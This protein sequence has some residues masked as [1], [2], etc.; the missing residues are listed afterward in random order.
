VVAALFLA[1]LWALPAAAAETPAGRPSANAASG[2][3]AGQAGNQPANQA[4]K[5]L[6]QP[7]NLPPRVAQAQRFLARRGWT[8]GAAGRRGWR[9][10]SA[11]HRSASAQL[12]A[13]PQGSG[14]QGSAG[15][16]TWKPLG[17]D[18]VLTPGY[19]LVTGRVSAMALD[20]S[21]TTGNHLYLG[22]AGD[23]VWAASNAATSSAS[24][25]LFTPLTDGID[26]LSGAED[27]SIS[28]G[29][30]TV[31]PGGSC[32]TGGD[33]GVILA[34]TGDPNDALDSYY[35]AGI[36]RSTDCG[37]SWSLISET[38]DTEWKFLGEG[39]A[40]FAW[41]TVNPQV[42]VAAVSQAYEGTLVN[43]DLTN[44]SYEGLYYS[45]DGGATWNLAT[46]TDGSGQD[47]QGP[48]DAF[49][50]PD[51]NAATAVVWNP[52][53]QLF[54]AAVR[55]HGYYQSAD[56]VT[57]TRMTAQPGAGLTASAC[58]TN[59]GGQIGSIGCPIFRGSLAVNPLTGDTF[60]WTVDMYN[61]DQG[62]WQDQCSINLGATACTN[63]TVTFARQ[64]DTAALE[65]NTGNGPATIQN[66]DYNL[67]LAAVPY[68]LQQGA[69]TWLLAGA[70]DLW[71]CSLAQGCVWRNTTNSTTCMSAQV[72]EFQHALAWDAANPLEIFVGNDG[73]LW[74]SL[75]AIGETS[76]VCAASD[77]THFQNLNGGLGS[78]AEVESLATSGS[79]AYVMMAGLGD[80][81]TAGLKSAT[82]VTADWPRILG[83]NGGPVVVDAA[84]SENWYV[85]NQN[86][87][88]IYLCSDPTS[89][90]AAG[91]G[92]TAVVNDAD[93]GGDGDT[94]QS[95]APFLIDPLDPSQ[96]LVG[97]CRV[98][99][100]PASGVG[101]SATNAVSPILDS[102]ATNVSCSGDAL[103]R[104]VA[105]MALSGGKEVV[106]VG[107]YGSNNG[108]ANLPGHVLSATIDPSSNSMPVWQDLTLNP[109][110]NSSN[111]L[112]K[113]GLDISSILVD[114]HDPTGKTVY[115]TVEGFSTTA[116]QVD[117]VYQSADGGA[118][119]AAL[120][121]NLPFTPVSGLAVDP[122]SASTVYLA[123]DV[124]VFFTTQV[125]GCANA[126]STC[127]SAFGSGLPQAPVVEL[128]A[129]P[130]TAPAQ[131]LTA[132]TFGRGVWQTALCSASGS[133][134]TSAS[135]NA[136]NLTFGNQ[137]VD[138]DSN[139]PLAVK[140]TNTGNLALTIS[141]IVMSDSE[142]FSESDDC[143]SGSVAA[144]ASCTVNVTFKP[145]A[146][147]A[148]AGEMAIDANVCGGQLTVGL[149]GT[150]TSTSVVTF[151][152]GALA[153]GNVAENTPV[154]LS[155]G[156]NT[157][158]TITAV[159]ITQ[160][161]PFTIA[162]NTCVA[163]MKLPGTCQVTVRFVPTASG[164]VNGILSFSDSAGTQTVVLTGTGQAPPTDILNPTSVSF[165]A[166]AVGQVSAAQ[167]VLLTNTG[168]LKLTSIAA[169]V[170]GDFQIQ[171]NNCGTQLAAHAACTIEVAFAPAQLGGQAG[172]L[173]V[174]D[175]LRTQTVTLVG[176]GV[177]PPALSVSLASL[178]FSSQLVGVASAPSLL[179]ITNTGAVAAAN[180][181]FQI[182][183]LDAG[184][185]ATGTTTCTASLR[186][187]SHC[188]V[189]VIFTPATA[190]GSEAI[191]TVSSS[192]S[193]VKPVTVLLEGA[194]KVLSGLNISPAQLS[195]AATVVGSA[196]AAQTVTISNTSGTA[197]SQ[198]SLAASA[199]FA[200]TQNTCSPTLAAGASCTV[201]V[202]F[203]P[204]AAGAITSVLNVSS[205]A[206]SNTAD[207]L[208]SGT[209]AAAAAIQVTPANL[210]F[211][212]TGVGQTSS[213]ITI[214]V[215]NTGIAT[216]L[217]N[218]ALAVPAG[219]ALANNTCAPSLGPGASCTAGVEFAPTSAGAQTGKLTVTTPTLTTGASAAL[220][221]MGFDFT[222]SVLGS[223]TQ[224]VAGGQ[225]AAYTL[226]LTPLNGSS[227]TFALVCDALPANAVCVFSPATET[228]TAGAIGNV[229][230]TI[231]T[232]ST[233]SLL[234]LKGRRGW[235]AL[236]LVCGLL[237]LPLGWKSR[238]KALHGLFL[239]ALVAVLAG[240]VASCVKSGGGTGSG[241]GG[242]GGS[243]GAAGTTP[244]GTYSVPVTVTSKVPAGVSHG[245]TLML[246][247]D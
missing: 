228:L 2:P 113:Y 54:V 211:P 176:T 207:V 104:S 99:R 202:V 234:R 49:V 172:V 114:S 102:G 126:S 98:W 218:L 35:G 7:L 72:A 86:G 41:S 128:N 108:G 45:G 182:S 109:V 215:T 120:T 217:S 96:L 57:W 151:N 39:F 90:D 219:F 168:D 187:A 66:G 143:V 76:A 111:T 31:Q 48:N 160:P 175:A 238:R 146:A 5:V 188:S 152:P 95:P 105:G 89:C 74:R 149:T 183:G 8:P 180:V 178:S 12:R 235:G 145:Q 67:A 4:A 52:V 241:T 194:G 130:A 213:P 195:F 100:G 230:V 106:Y 71:K 167:P 221:G 193:G 132:A 161:S 37:N 79:S 142:D 231:S 125:S 33:T 110:T 122:L 65:T 179:T 247:V 227:G 47:V 82:A 155:V 224:S 121:S 133:G 192:T 30:L 11:G 81:G 40:G 127:W 80:N 6:P 205:P 158:V 233:T 199:G 154:Q 169:T 208:L 135:T 92:N 14:Q 18:A 32:G 15:T 117:T 25:V 16:A 63:Q 55:F 198:L 212:T 61:Q 225:N 62:L 88:S 157:P 159:S 137:A 226:V 10:I 140:V 21:D 69:D 153:F 13:A 115:V 93:V 136:M 28:I 123:T 138:T 246:T 70:N 3:D 245:T 68:A 244:A 119:W 156:I 239:L 129:S 42:V 223:S 191:L 197:A 173:T 201:G 162:S 214:T 150:G 116:D 203:A 64:W 170:S 107:M 236:P 56:G 220:Q 148:L 165:S 23:G 232:G 177:A 174:S 118:H 112:N 166:A 229:A 103:I 44:R 46:I 181:G 237:L 240:G 144:G 134:Q 87:V 147:G 9:R 141:S 50:N 43:V 184:S 163:S 26:A 243:G 209:G 189:Q 84:N 51:G 94:M 164:L 77:A 20:P 17:P 171:S 200:L 29:A 242:S 1:A 78:L 73:G 139:P 196:S 24:Q 97:T 124:G 190:G 59:A 75:D 131:V 58:P 186:S 210:A 185:F 60:A 19:G 85:N 216:T 222:V 101:W 38:A 204:A 53:R 27:A 34:G 22:T 91:F 206:I 83:G 36:L